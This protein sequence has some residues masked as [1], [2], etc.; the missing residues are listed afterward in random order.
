MCLLWHLASG[1]WC[2]TEYDHCHGGLQLKA[3]WLGQQNS[4]RETQ[5]FWRGNLNKSRHQGTASRLPIRTIWGWSYSGH[6][7]GLGVKWWWARER[8]IH[9]LRNSMWFNKAKEERWTKRIERSQE[10]D[11]CVCWTKAWSSIGWDKRLWRANY[12]SI[13]WYLAFDRWCTWEYYHR[14]GRLHASASWLRQ[15][16]PHWE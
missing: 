2:T 10:R 8:E 15:Q 13:L 7:H 1:W 12:L 6:L 14:H 16:D 11:L 5:A 4:Q 9:P 3:S